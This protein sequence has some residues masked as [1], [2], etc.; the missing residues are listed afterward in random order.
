MPKVLTLITN[1]VEEIEL[2]TPHDI[3][4]RAGVENTLVAVATNGARSVKGKSELDIATNATLDEIAGAEKDFAKLAEKFDALFLP[5]G[6]GTWSLL[7]DGNAAKVAAAFATKGKLI[8]AICAAPLILDAAGLLKGKQIAAHFCTWKELPAASICPPVVHC[9]NMITARGP[10]AAFAF[11]L[12]IVEALCG[13]TA[14]EKVA[15]ETMA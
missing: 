4:L 1:G 5:G 3:M 8:A 2:V 6:P 11:G 13:K 12:A 10:G 9:D 14:A 7:D 15:A